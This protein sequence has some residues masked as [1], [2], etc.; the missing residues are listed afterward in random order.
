MEHK[1]QLKTE[2]LC[3]F[4]YIMNFPIFINFWAFLVLCSLVS[5]SLTMFF[6]DSEVCLERCDSCGDFGYLTK[7][8]IFLFEEK[9]VKRTC[10]PS[11]V[12]LALLLFLC[13]PSLSINTL[14]SSRN[15]QTPTGSLRRCRQYKPQRNMAKDMECC[16]VQV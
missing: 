9:F 6:R 1:K 5:N 14:R 11:I 16:V 10:C 15:I 13:R 4:V 8:Q 2:Q 3:N 7:N 12:T